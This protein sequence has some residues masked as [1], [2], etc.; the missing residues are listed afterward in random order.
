MRWYNYFRNVFN[1]GKNVRRFSQ[2]SKDKLKG[3]DPDIVAVLNIAI[4]ESPYDFSIVQGV[5]SQDYQ[6]ELYTQGR[7]TAALRA[8]GIMDKEG[9]PHLPKV[10]WTRNSK[11]I[12]AEDGYGKAIDFA[13]Y[14]DG[15]ISWD[16]KYYKPIADKIISVGKKM[17]VELESGA[18]WNTPDWGHIQKKEAV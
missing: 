9:K 17:G 7:T 16:D 6:D 5:R 15:K 8:A 13:A 12:P 1:M 10:T 14:I 2:N 11:H 4:I 18:Y 3:V